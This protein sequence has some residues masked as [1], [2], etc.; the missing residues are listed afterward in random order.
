MH[1]CTAGLMLVYIV[2]SGDMLVGKPG[3][4]GLACDYLGDVKYCHWAC[5]RPVVTGLVV[6]FILLPLNS[7]R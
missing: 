7:F 1:W 5:N 4:K 3:F 6:V 2:I